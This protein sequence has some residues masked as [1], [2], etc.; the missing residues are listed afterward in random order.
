[1]FGWVP[2]VKN[3]YIP[4]VKYKEISERVVNV[5]S[6]AP[7]GDQYLTV[8]VVSSGGEIGGEMRARIHA[9]E[10]MDLLNY[11]VVARGDIVYAKTVE[12]GNHRSVVHT[13]HGHCVHRRKINAYDCVPMFFNIKRDKYRL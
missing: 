1:M 8:E 10:P 4:Q 7:S 6:C 13:L 11:A 9:T 12:V 5:Q 2:K 3:T